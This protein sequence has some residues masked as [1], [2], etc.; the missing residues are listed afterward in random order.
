MF[1][2]EW[3]SRFVSRLRDLLVREEGSDL[4]LASGT[5][6]RWLAPGEVIR[7]GQMPTTFGPVDLELKA[8]ENNIVGQVRLP[9]RNRFNHARLGLRVPQSRRIESVRIDG[10]RSPRA[11]LLT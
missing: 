5:P 8:G 9:S 7:M 6:R 1:K 3:R 4:W 11:G 2:P 10:S